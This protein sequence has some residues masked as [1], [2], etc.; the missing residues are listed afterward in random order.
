MNTT[1]FENNT[2]TAGV[3][4]MALELSQAKWVIAFGNG[5]KRGQITIDAA[6]TV[7]LE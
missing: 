7:R 6:D 5:V 2:V 1:R 3:L 4:Y